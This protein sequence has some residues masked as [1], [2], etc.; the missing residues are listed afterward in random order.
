MRFFRNFFFAQSNQHG[1]LTLVFK[2]ILFFSPVHRVIRK[3]V[4]A[5][6]VLHCAGTVHFDELCQKKKFYLEGPL[7]VDVYPSLYQI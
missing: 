6:A 7:K 3:H 4:R 1:G 2:G 5:R